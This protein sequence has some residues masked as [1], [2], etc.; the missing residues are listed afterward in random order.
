MTEEYQKKLDKVIGKPFENRVTHIISFPGFHGKRPEQDET[1]S[2]E[3]DMETET[4]QQMDE[5]GWTSGADCRFE[6][7]PQDKG[8]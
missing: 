2:L 6:E 5:D 1:E 8:C 3:T 7:L 4:L